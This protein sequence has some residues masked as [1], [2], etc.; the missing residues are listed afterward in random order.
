MSCDLLLAAGAGGP[1]GAASAVAC[2]HAT[3]QV[4][5]G[6]GLQV[7]RCKPL[8]TTASWV[9]PHAVPDW[10]GMSWVVEQH[11]RDVA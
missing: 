9:R 1:E 5:S 2:R 7:A 6:H 11:Q 4:V 10:Q 8:D 3:A